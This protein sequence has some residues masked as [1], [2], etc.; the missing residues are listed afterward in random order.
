[1]LPPSP[2]FSTCTLNSGKSATGCTG[3]SPSPTGRGSLVMLGSGGTAG[4]GQQLLK[5]RHTVL[6]CTHVGGAPA[7]QQRF[8]LAHAAAQAVHFIDRTLGKIGLQVEQ[9]RERVVGALR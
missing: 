5:E 6:E 1:M 9:G 8:Q 7:L 4:F 2:T 3:S